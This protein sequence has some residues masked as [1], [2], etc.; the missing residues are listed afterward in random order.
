[1][2]AL[3]QTLGTLLFLGAIWGGVAVVAWVLD[4][5]PTEPDAQL[6]EAAPDDAGVDAPMDAFTPPSADRPAT[7]EPKPPDHPPEPDAPIEPELIEPARPAEPI[8][9]FA[10]EAP[11]EEPYVVS[12]VAGDLLGDDRP[13]LVVGLG[14]RIEVLG[15][16]ED[17]ALTRLLVIHHRPTN[18]E[19]TPS[20]PRV[21]IGDAT[22]DGVTDLVIAFW[23]RAHSLGSRGGGAWILRGK[24]DGSLDRPRRFA[25]PRMMISS[26]DLLDVDGRDGNEIVLSDRGR[27]YGDIPGRVRIY[28]ASRRPRPLRDFSAE[29]NDVRM[30]LPVHADGDERV[31]L[32]AYGEAVVRFRNTGG[33]RFERMEGERKGALFADIYHGLSADL[34]RDGT[35]E[36][37]AY[38]RDFETAVVIV[39][40]GGFRSV[41]G[42]ADPMRRVVPGD[43]VPAPVVVAGT[44]THSRW[45]LATLGTNGRLDDRRV[46]RRAGHLEGV[47]VIGTGHD[48]VVVDL[49]GD[50]AL[51]LVTLDTAWHDHRTEWQLA[52]G[53]L[54]GQPSHVRG[55][56]DGEP[57]SHDLR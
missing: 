46:I 21:A 18:A 39:D 7:D 9:V 5:L 25:G 38:P 54:E 47:S 26:I 23:R 41:P 36:A 33:G 30:V 6:P 2:R 51:E 56:L 42:T 35:L 43:A 31:D 28:R 44:S 24:A 20:T 8:R 55:S 57:A 3:G 16:A 11:E 52:I 48:A 19:T 17:G 32:V 1:M 53:P 37:Y 12:L 22:G 4:A 34:D 15:L 13:E 50:G 40:E 29:T 10:L 49:D 45:E 27:P 14:E